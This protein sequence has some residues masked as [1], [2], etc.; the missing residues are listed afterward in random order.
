[1]GVMPVVKHSSPVLLNEVNQLIAVAQVHFADQRLQE[2]YETAFE[3]ML[4]A[5]AIVGQAHP[6]VA[7]CQRCVHPS[8]SLCFSI[9]VVAS[10]GAWVCVHACPRPHDASVLC[11]AACWPSSYGRRETSVA[12]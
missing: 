6:T 1:M 2:A 3:A 11:R 9:A 7:T 5:S 8:R 10:V 12:P 4:V